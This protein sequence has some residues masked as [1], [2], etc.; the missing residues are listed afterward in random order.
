M[1]LIIKALEALQMNT[2]EGLRKSTTAAH[3]YI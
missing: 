3:T 2:V 1:A